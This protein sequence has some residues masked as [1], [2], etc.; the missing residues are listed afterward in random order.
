[1]DVALTEPSVVEVEGARMTVEKLE[2]VATEAIDV[3]NLS[4]DLVT[5]VK[6]DLPRLVRATTEV[7]PEATVRVTPLL[8]RRILGAVP[9]LVW[10][11]Y[12]W[13]PQ[14]ET[15]EVTV[16]GPAGALREA[17]PDTVIAV[18]HLPDTP[19]RD[20]YEASFGPNEGVR[21]RVVHPRGDQVKI[22]KVVPDVVE[23]QRK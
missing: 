1:V 5:Q 11:Q 23:V 8:E 13:V 15:V 6:L 9:V 7:L 10:Q 21:L 3:S 18:V 16:E 2:S 22:V 20:K 17:G 12:G 14:Q 4:R 19:E